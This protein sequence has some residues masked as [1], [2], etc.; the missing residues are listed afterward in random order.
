M[1]LVFFLSLSLSLSTKAQQQYGKHVHD[2]Q[3]HL[4]GIKTKGCQTCTL[5]K[6]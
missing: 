6:K 1:V 2:L 5:I 3:G 4:R